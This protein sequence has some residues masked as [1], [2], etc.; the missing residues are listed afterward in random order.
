VAND[1]TPQ[2]P[3][4]WLLDRLQAC[5]ASEG[6]FD[7]AALLDLLNEGYASA[8]E[9][10]RCLEAAA[11][12]AVSAGN[13]S[14]SLPA[15]WVATLGVYEGGQRLTPL[16]EWDTGEQALTGTYFELAGSLGFPITSTIGRTLMLHYAQKP[17]YASLSDALDARFPKE[18]HYLIRHYA[19]WRIYLRSGGAQ[20]MGKATFERNIF[21]LGCR[22]LARRRD[23]DSEAPRRI[24]HAFEAAL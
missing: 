3:M 24:A 18:W 14:V 5:V 2:A 7:D 19:A 12:L 20:D 6:E 1:Y 9:R 8:C 11:A 17:V 21:E 15:D 13:A 23:V 4:K 10:S 16:P 22:Q